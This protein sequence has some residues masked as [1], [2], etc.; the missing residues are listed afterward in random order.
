MPP[1]T[2]A[3]AQ[4]FRVFLAAFGIVLLT[5]AVVLFREIMLA[6]LLGIMIGALLSPLISWL[7][8][9]ARLP[10]RVGVIVA[11]LAL[12]GI[13]GGVGWA[14]YAAVS[15]QAHQLAGRTPELIDAL[16]RL[17]EQAIERLSWL[18][19]STENLNLSETFQSSAQALF[20][21]LRISLQAVV[22]GAVVLMVAVF[23]AANARAYRDGFLTLFPPARRVSAARLVHGS[24]CAVRRWLGSQLMV[25]GISGI[26]TG[27]ALLLIGSEYWLLIALLTVVL[28]FVPFFGL[29]VTALLATLLTL[30]T[31][32]HKV[33]W[34][35][36]AYLLIQQIEND[37]TLPIVMRQRIRVPEAHLLVFLLLMGA[38][39]GALGVFVAAP[40]FAI[41][42]YL[43]R[44]AYV[45]WVNAR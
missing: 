10:H 31:E 40:V 39:F 34:V 30:A 33:W 15:E 8:R 26:L 13:V 9:R 3:T 23:T 14:I 20:T 45:P 27:L 28:D 35:L 18:G 2:P 6:S 42:H 1:T 36:L 5:V 32:P 11:V 43:Y 22:I 37:V 7:Q 41:L 25:A 21:G 17:A 29:L 12:L 16:A 38:A 44:E 4:A 19:V 24:A